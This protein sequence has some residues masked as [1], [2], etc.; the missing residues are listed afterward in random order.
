MAT[1]SHVS[2]EYNQEEIKN[3]RKLKSTPEELRVI[4]HTWSRGN[5]T[6]KSIPCREAEAAIN[7]VYLANSRTDVVEEDHTFATG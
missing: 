2:I 3:K 5:V 4:G 1:K 7:A 6:L